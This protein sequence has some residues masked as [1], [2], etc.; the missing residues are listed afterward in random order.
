[1]TDAQIANLALLFAR[2]A[3]NLDYAR[4]RFDEAR[5]RHERAIDD[6]T[7]ARAALADAAVGNRVFVLDGWVV[8]D[9]G[10]NLGV[11]ARKAIVLPPTVQPS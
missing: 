4:L 11:I 1:M 2:A 10:G 8:E 5:D 3:A 6:H 7:K 9:A